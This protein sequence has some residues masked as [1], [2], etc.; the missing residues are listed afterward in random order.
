M[1]KKLISKPLLECFCCQLKCCHVYRRCSE[2]TWSV[3]WSCRT[4]TTSLQRTTTSWLTRGGKSGRKESRCWPVPTPSQNPRPGSGAAT[5]VASPMRRWAGCDGGS[6]CSEFSRRGPKRC[7]T[8]TRGS[9]SRAGARTPQTRVPSTS[10]S[11]R[12]PCVATTWT[13]WT[14][15]GWTRS[16]ESWKEWVKGG[17]PLNQQTGL[18]WTGTGS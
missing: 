17:V 14:T 6:L 15:T 8:A 16:T 1:C 5:T 2:K 11:W 7:F 12:R 4:P 10:G 9:T 3:P 18:Y 13:T